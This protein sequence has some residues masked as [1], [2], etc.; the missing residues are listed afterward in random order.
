MRIVI[1]GKPKYQK[2]HR[3]GNGRTWNPSAKDK[4]AIKLSAQAQVNE[5]PYDIPLSV[6]ITAYYPFLKSWTKSQK[7]IGEG[8]PKITKPD[9]DN[10]AKLYCDALNGVA[11]TD[12]NIIT[13]LTV[14]KLYSREPCVV[15]DVEPYE[16]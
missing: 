7:A 1:Q 14:R 8:A 12:D 11:W 13:K 3:H 10:I 15:I 6:E 16:V 4:K 9:A 5:K 2:R